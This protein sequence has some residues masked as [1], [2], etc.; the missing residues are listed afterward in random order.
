MDNRLS[1]NIIWIDDFIMSIKD[2]IN[3]RKEEKLL[4]LLPNQVFQLNETATELLSYLLEGNSIYTL[5]DFLDENKME[6]VQNFMCDL[7][8]L[9]MGCV[10]EDQERKAIEYIPYRRYFY[11]YP[12]LSEVAITYRCNAACLFCY[13]NC[14]RKEVEELRTDEAKIILKKIKEEAKVP[15]VSFTGGEPTLREDLLQLITYARENGLRVNLI[16][17]GLI[18]DEAYAR[19][20]KRAGLNSAQISLES[21]IEEIHDYL[22]QVRGSF[23]KTISSILFLKAEGI[24]VHTN[25]TI[26]KINR[27]SLTNLIDLVADLGLKRLSMNM[28]M[29]CG[30]VVSSN[31]DKLQMKYSEIGEIVLNLKKKADEKGIEFLWY[32]PTP[33]CL[34]NPIQ[35][36]LGNKSCSAAFGLLSIDSLGNVLPCSSLNVPLGNLL[37][38]SFDEIWFSEKSLYYRQLKFAPSHCH[39]CKLFEICGAACPIYFE[40]F[41]FD[42]TKALRSPL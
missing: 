34:F 36:K 17:N 37:D 20:L 27:G 5:I 42:E 18:I 3:V 24:N 13:A 32:S 9:L 16:S 33:Y 40:K 11:K 28:I 7:R 25:S 14:P 30:S 4:I 22:T 29:P 15:S 8:A 12:I 1:K 10:K 6:D 2:Y 31:I 41:K 23:R 38:N 19:E 39:N 26:N 21:G 35:Y